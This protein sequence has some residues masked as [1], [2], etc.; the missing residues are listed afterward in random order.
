MSLY[1][2][3]FKE[4]NPFAKFAII[5]LY[6]PFAFL[7]HEL[8]PFIGVLILL[9]RVHGRTEDEVQ[10][11]NINIWTIGFRDS[12]FVTGAALIFKVLISQLNRLY[13]NILNSNLGM[14][15]TPQEI[16][17]EFAVGELYYKLLLFALVV[18]LAP[19]VEE[20]IFRYYIYDKLLLPRMPAVVAAVIASA[21]FTLLHYNISGIP[22]F[23]GLGLYCTFM[24]E[25][26]GFYGA[27][28]THVV[29]NLVTAAFLM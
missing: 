22:T 6:W 25:K 15:T 28:I 7:T 2:Y 5:I 20:Y 19:F 12:A 3:V 1:K 16:V 29:S 24:Y 10:T 26:K 14:E 13:V 21:F 17:E 18:V 11:R 8:I 27:V 4:F 9:Y 23:F